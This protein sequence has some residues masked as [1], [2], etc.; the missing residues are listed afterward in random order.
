MNTN[1]D[2]HLHNFSKAIKYIVCIATTEIRWINNQT[3]V[4]LWH[5]CLH[6]WMPKSFCGGT[7]YSLLFRLE[8]QSNLGLKKSSGVLPSPTINLTHWVP[9]LYCVPLCHDLLKINEQQLRAPTTQQNS[10]P[11]WGK[12]FGSRPCCMKMLYILLTFLSKYF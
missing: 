5:T 10:I 7:E 8:S 11:F 6:P 1:A 3:P 4:L 12:H 2:E 9:P